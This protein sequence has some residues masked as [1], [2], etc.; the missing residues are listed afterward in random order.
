MNL[1]PNATERFDATFG[2]RRGAILLQNSRSAHHHIP[3]VFFTPRQAA[4]GI[5]MT[6]GVP[7]LAGK[8]RME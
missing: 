7:A 8:W 3:N 1:S 4:V 5:V 6:D 2:S